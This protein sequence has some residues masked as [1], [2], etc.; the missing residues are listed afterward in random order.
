MEIRKALLYVER[1]QNPIRGFYIKP[2]CKR[3]FV[4][5]RFNSYEAYEA[6]DASISSV[7][8]QEAPPRPPTPARAAF[9]A[10]ERLTVG[11]ALTPAAVGGERNP[12]AT[13]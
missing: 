6:D 11:R 7:R 9:C 3:G 8:A 10:S 4:L 5:P 2:I 1:Y 13:R 12:I